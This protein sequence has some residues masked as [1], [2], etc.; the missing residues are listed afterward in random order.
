MADLRSWSLLPKHALRDCSPA[1]AGTAP[2]RGTSAESSA[3]AK[4]APAPFAGSS[5]TSA[6]KKQGKQEPRAEDREEDPR[7]HQNEENTEYLP[8][9][10]VRLLSLALITGRRGGRRLGQTIQGNMTVL[11]YHLRDLAH[12][13]YGSTVVI[14][15]PQQRDHIAAKA[16]YF[17]VGK[18]RLESVSNFCPIFVIVDRKQHHHASVCSLVAHA[19][20]LEKVVRE[21]FSRIALQGFDRDNADLGLGFLINFPAEPRQLFHGCRVERT[22][23]I[24]DVSMRI[25]LLPLFR[26]GRHGG[27]EG[28]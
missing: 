16:T 6:P 12:D 26:M 18:N 27:N 19:P 22:A 13:L 24:V 3:A 9:C 4:S 17:A 10:Y 25:E 23:K 5:P 11:R 21:V 20:L 7:H 1:S 15:L 2:A 14:A 28:E 8:R